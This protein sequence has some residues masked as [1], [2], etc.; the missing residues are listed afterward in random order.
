MAQKISKIFWL[1]FFGFFLYKLI[2]K[3]Y[4]FIDGLPDYMGKTELFDQCIFV[5]H[6]FSGII[7][8]TTA[9]LQFTP[10]I[11]KH[12]ILFHRRTGKLYIV[13]SFL[14]IVSLYFMIPRGLCPSC[15]PSQ[16]IVTSLWLTFVLF[17]FYFI[18]QGKVL[19][20]QRM[21]ISSFICAAYFVTIRVVDML[22]MPFFYS[23][24]DTK[25]QAFLVSDI[26]VWLIPLLTFWTYWIVKKRLRLISK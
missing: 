25:D 14:C 12:N 18:K 13:A 3:Y 10:S 20:H 17:A 19:L 26:S 8:Y 22:A 11:R 15:R 24:T 2:P 7:V 16:Y 4:Y 6:I 1:L 9:V 5:L 21:M 23:I